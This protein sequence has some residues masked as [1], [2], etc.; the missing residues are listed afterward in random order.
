MRVDVACEGRSSGERRGARCVSTREFL[1]TCFV[2]LP[3]TKQTR[4]LKTLATEKAT[5][6]RI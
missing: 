6:H 1:Q 2:N 3:V 4:L 5:F